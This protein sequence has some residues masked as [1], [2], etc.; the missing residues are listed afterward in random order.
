[1][2]RLIERERE[3]GDNIEQMPRTSDVF[4]PPS[5][6]TDPSELA[7]AETQELVSLATFSASRM[8]AKPFG[9]TVS[10]PQGPPSLDPTAAAILH[11]AASTRFSAD[12][13]REVQ[14]ITAVLVQEVPRR[15]KHGAVAT[16]VAMLFCAAETKAHDNARREDG[17]ESL[18]PPSLIQE[19]LLNVT[20]GAYCVH[21]QLAQAHEQLHDAVLAIDRELETALAELSAPD[22]RPDGA[23]ASTLSGLCPSPPAPPPAPMSAAY[24]PGAAAEDEYE[25]GVELLIAPAGLL[26]VP[27]SGQFEGAMAHKVPLRPFVLLLQQR[28]E[29][30]SKLHNGVLS[31]ADGGAAQ[32]LAAQVEAAC[33]ALGRPCF[34]QE[35]VAAAAGALAQ[36]QLEQLP[37]VAALLASADVRLARLAEVQFDKI[38]RQVDMVERRLRS[39]DEAAAAAGAAAK[40]GRKQSGRGMPNCSWSEGKRKKMVVEA[41]RQLWKRLAELAELAGIVSAAA[42]RTASLSP[43]SAHMAVAAQLKRMRFSHLEDGQPYR[44]PE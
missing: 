36:T 32:H 33:S 8:S 40:V 4:D 16:T 41:S 27:T 25:C 28:S 29:A 37:A 9:L 13:Q 12:L 5:D 44:S 2:Y 23:P 20:C 19:E 14:R 21:E 31:S 34:T 3:S 10:Q 11:A 43:L 26:L 42:R 30:V 39:W 24:T 7:G 17:Q 1:M 22:E 15:R 6:A 38:G 18:L 35:F